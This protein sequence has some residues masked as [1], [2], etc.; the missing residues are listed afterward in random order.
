MNDKPEP[1]V[2]TYCGHVYIEKC[3]GKSDCPNRIWLDE[4]RKAEPKEEAK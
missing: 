2:C 1:R 3:D 4:H